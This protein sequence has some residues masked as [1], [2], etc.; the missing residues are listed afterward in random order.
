MVEESKVV[1]VGKR[2]KNCLLGNLK[3]NLY[4]SFVENPMEI[5]Q[6]FV[7]STEPT[8]LKIPFQQDKRYNGGSSISD[9]VIYMGP[10]VNF[11]LSPTYLDY[12]DLQPL[13]GCLMYNLRGMTEEEQKEFYSKPINEQEVLFR[14]K[15]TATHPLYISLREGVF[16][17]PSKRLVLQSNSK[18]DFIRQE[19]INPHL[20]FDNFDPL[21]KRLVKKRESLREIQNMLQSDVNAQDIYELVDERSSPLPGPSSLCV[22]VTP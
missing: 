21:P 5:E 14:Q 11:Q 22:P 20:V 19:E 3:K 9:A 16:Y 17:S 2:R 1:F 10:P 8:V 4:F 13:E 7:R 18:I 12:I 6:Q 15:I